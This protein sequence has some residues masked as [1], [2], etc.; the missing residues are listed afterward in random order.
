MRVTV[1]I[2]RNFF[3]AL[4]KDLQRPHAIAGE[5]VGFLFAKE[6]DATPEER[7]LF[8]IEY[9]PV[10]DEDYLATNSVGASFNTSAIR[11]ALQRS[12]TS[13]WSCLQVHMHDHDGHTGFSAVDRKTI[14]ELA[15]S[16]R[17]VAPRAS[18][19]GVVFSRQ[20][21]TARIWVPGVTEPAVSRVVIVGFPMRLGPE[22]R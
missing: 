2:Q 12:R 14:D 3:G 7:L 10:R 11:S 16:L 6:A 20:S 1:R 21:A 8:P 5:R 9:E 13:G 15:A 18:H 4:I 17:V 22:A 19:G